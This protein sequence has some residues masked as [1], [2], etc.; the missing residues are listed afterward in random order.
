MT[1]GTSL[2]SWDFPDH[3]HTPRPHRGSP[4]PP[5]PASAPPGEAPETEAESRLSG[6]GLLSVWHESGREGLGALGRI[7]PADTSTFTL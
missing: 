1:L 5:S 6:Q 4:L 7:C 3:V 2:S